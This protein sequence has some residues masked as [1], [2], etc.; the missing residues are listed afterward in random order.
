MMEF[1][2]SLTVTAIHA[3]LKFSIEFPYILQL[4]SHVFIDIFFQSNPSHLVLVG[5]HVV[6]VELGKEAVG[7]KDSNGSA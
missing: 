4:H 6:V 2:P 5:S 7:G 3:Y 1:A